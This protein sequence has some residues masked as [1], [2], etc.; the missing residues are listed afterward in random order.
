MNLTNLT[1]FYEKGNWKPTHDIPEKAC[2]NGSGYIPGPL[3]WRLGA[4]FGMVFLMAW[5]AIGTP[6]LALIR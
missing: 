3:Y 4:I 2:S 1:I 5:L 6:W